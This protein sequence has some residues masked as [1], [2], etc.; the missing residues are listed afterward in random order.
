MVS[1]RKSFFQNCHSYQRQAKE[2]MLIKMLKNISNENMKYR[3]GKPK[4][5]KQ[6]KSR[7]MSIKK[8]DSIGQ[9]ITFSRKWTFLI[10]KM[11]KFMKI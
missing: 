1:I 10:P 6:A 8:P 7:I 4:I 2:N 11:S 3:T 9:N 5:R